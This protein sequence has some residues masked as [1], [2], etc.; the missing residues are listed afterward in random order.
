MGYKPETFKEKEIPTA[1]NKITAKVAE[2]KSGVLKDFIDKDALEKWKNSTPDDPCIEVVVVCEDGTQRKRTMPYPAD[3]A[4]DPRSNL[5]KW[6]KAYGV[7]PAEGQ[8]LFLIAD[9]EGFY[10]F[11]V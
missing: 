3:G 4:I 8:D 10:Q 1:G 7:Y 5:G 2:I 6:K 9:A 11:Q